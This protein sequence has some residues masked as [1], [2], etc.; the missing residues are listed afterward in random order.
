MPGADGRRGARR[1]AFDLA[2]SPGHF[3][4]GA[5]RAG[6]AAMARTAGMTRRAHLAV[7]NSLQSPAE[8]A[9]TLKPALRPA[10]KSFLTTWSS[11]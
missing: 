3:I 11:F 8:R 4:P 10:S 9:S 7:V 5:G 2:L 1:D 6:R